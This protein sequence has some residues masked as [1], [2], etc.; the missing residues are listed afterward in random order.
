MDKVTVVNSSRGILQRNKWKGMN[1]DTQQ[2][3]WIWKI[4]CKGKEI[5]H[6]RALTAWVH[7]EVQKQAKTN[8]NVR[9]L[10]GG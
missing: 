8:P 5:W 1:R 3:G 4:W 7:D 2:H 9:S 10:A 6:K